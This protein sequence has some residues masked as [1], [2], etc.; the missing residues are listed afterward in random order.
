MI[1]PPSSDS[2]DQ[3]LISESQPPP[4]ILPIIHSGFRGFSQIYRGL[5]I[6]QKLKNRP[7]RR[8]PPKGTIMVFNK[9]HCL[10]TT[11]DQGQRQQTWRNG[12]IS[13]R[14][15]SEIEYVPHLYISYTLL[16]QKLDIK[17]SASLRI[18][19]GPNFLA[20]FCRFA[21]IINTIMNNKKPI[22]ISSDGSAS[23]HPCSCSCTDY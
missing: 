5:G 2:S 7:K 20:K 12:E 3:P 14:L 11:T 6:S 18:F 16:L 17:F 4:N 19:L 22:D 23:L 8:F 21:L 15:E 10:T 9:R 13:P 1:S